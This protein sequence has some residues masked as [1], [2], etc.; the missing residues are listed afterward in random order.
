MGEKRESAE[1]KNPCSRRRGGGFVRR[2]VRKGELGRARVPGS[3]LASPEKGL[4]PGSAEGV[5]KS[6]DGALFTVVKVWK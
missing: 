4:I 3:G 5:P 1:G 6:P 2:S